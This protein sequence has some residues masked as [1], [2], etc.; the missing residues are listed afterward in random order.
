MTRD[1]VELHVRAGEL[2]G[3]G[4]WVY[5][6]LLGPRVI[7]VGTTGLPPEVRTWLHLHDPDPAVGRLRARHPGIAADD[8]DVLAFR[9]PDGTDRPRA[10][11][12][13]VAGLSAAG[14][15]S[16]H[17]VGDPPSAGDPSFA[18][19]LDRITTALGERHGAPAV[20]RQP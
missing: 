6:W 19:L 20:R 7:Y 18:S 3:S 1:L 13:A 10:K 2:A 14:W 8:L 16:E 4:S 12:A 17:Y 15:F 11:A 5:L 9:L